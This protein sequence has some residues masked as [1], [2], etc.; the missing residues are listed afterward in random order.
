MTGPAAAEESTTL[1][2]HGRARHNLVTRHIM[3]SQV[4]PSIA[5]MIVDSRHDGLVF[6]I[7]RGSVALR[8]CLLVIVDG[9]GAKGG[10]SNHFNV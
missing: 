4:L 8:R 5:M 10:G 2:G 7:P 6:K 9:T 1:V 3:D